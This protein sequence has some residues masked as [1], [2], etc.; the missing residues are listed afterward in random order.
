MSVHFKQTA[1]KDTDKALAAANPKASHKLL[2]G[3]SPASF[4]NVAARKAKMLTPESCLQDDGS[5]AGP[6]REAEA[7]SKKLTERPW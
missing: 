5:V 2:I 4:R 7:G 6:P 1:L 3:E